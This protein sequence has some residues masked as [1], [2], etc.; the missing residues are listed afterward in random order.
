MPLNQDYIQIGSDIIGS[1]FDVRNKTGRGLREKYYE[2]ALAHEL[3]LKGYDVK[4]QVLI[5]ALYCNEIIDDSYQAD[6]IVND[7]VII[8]VKAL[9]F[10]KEHEGRQLLT[11]LKLS[12]YKLGYLINFGA[13]NFKIGKASEE[14]PYRNGIYRFVNNI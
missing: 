2:A 14:F 12:Q 8:E 1:A 13:I 3:S 5:P 11:Y 6:I 9:K 10:M 4:R 7:N